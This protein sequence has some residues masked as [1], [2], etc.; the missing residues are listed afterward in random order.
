MKH[1]ISIS[2]TKNNLEKIRSFVESTLTDY[3]ISELETHKLVLAVDEICA[4][5]IIHAN[6]CD[7]D[8][9]LDLKMIV[10]PLERIE[11]IIKD[12]GVGFDMSKYKEPKMNELVATKRKGGL[13]LML[14]KRIMDEI[15]FATEKNHNICRLIKNL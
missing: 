14:V 1:K 12:K 10:I 7:P 11:F 5:L 15:E 6:K 13:G 9:H 4:N 2:C 8:S 3:G